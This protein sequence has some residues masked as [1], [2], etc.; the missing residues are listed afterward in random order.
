M[1]WATLQKPLFQAGLAGA[2][3]V[4]VT[5]LFKHSKGTKP[6]YAFAGGLLLTFASYHIWKAVALARGED[7][8][9]V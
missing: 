2:N 3:M 6:L 8:P 5:L 1:N 9:P 7:V 4:G